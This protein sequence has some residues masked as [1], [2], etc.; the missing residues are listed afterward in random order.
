MTPAG[1]NPP[2]R[3]RKPACKP[4]STPC[5]QPNPQT[6]SSSFATLAAASSSSPPQKPTP[7]LPVRSRRPSTT[8]S[9]KRTPTRASTPSGTTSPRLL[10]NRE[11]TCDADSHRCPANSRETPPTLRVRPNSP[12]STLLPSPA[13]PK[14]TSENNASASSTPKP[15]QSPPLDPHSKPSPSVSLP[16]DSSTSSPRPTRTLPRSTKSELTLI[17]AGDPPRSLPTS[18]PA[19]TPCA[20]NSHHFLDK[21]RTTS[22]ASLLP[23]LLPPAEEVA[24]LLLLPLPIPARPNMMFSSLA[25]KLLLIPGRLLAPPAPVLIPYVN[26]MLKQQQEALLK[27]SISTSPALCAKLRFKLSPYKMTRITSTNFTPM[28]LHA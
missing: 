19:L 9:P 6:A 20:P 28:L 8:V 14:L 24:G 10:T 27:S 22:T 11:S 1:P 17:S 18:P 3:R 5:R 25:R 16:A 7:T 12:P 15:P 26:K 21:P 13:L 23:P 2:R 4:T